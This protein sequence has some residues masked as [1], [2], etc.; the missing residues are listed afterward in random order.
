MRDSGGDADIAFASD[1]LCHFLRR[2]DPLPPRIPQDDLESLVKCLACVFAPGSCVQSQSP[3]Y[4]AL[5]ANWQELWDCFP[6]LKNALDCSRLDPPACYDSLKGPLCPFLS[7]VSPSHPPLP[8]RPVFPRLFFRIEAFFICIM[9]KL[10]L[11]GG[12]GT[13]GEPRF[14]A[15]NRD[16]SPAVVRRWRS[17]RVCGRVAVGADH[18]CNRKPM[19]RIPVRFKSAFFGVITV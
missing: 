1:R 16:F 10:P 17:G 19:G 11:V 6:F 4:E 9:T 18:R 2:R 3:S 7:L 15:R 12:R 14:L 5:E 13:S 8:A